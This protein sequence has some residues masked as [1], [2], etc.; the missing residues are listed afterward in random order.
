MSNTV[1]TSLPVQEI[2]HEAPANATNSASSGDKPAVVAATP[3]EESS[4]WDEV[5][6]QPL[7]TLYHDQMI[8]SPSHDEGDGE[9]EEGK[10]PVVGEIMD[11]DERSVEAVE[12]AAGAERIENKTEKGNVSSDKN[13]DECLRED[14]VFD[15]ELVGGAL[16]EDKSNRAE[17][18]VTSDEDETSSGESSLKRFSK[19]SKSSEE[20]K[21]DCPALKKAKTLPVKKDLPMIKAP[22]LELKPLPPLPKQPPRKRPNCLFVNHFG[23]RL[24]QKG[25]A[26]KVNVSTKVPMPAPHRISSEESVS[27]K[28]RST[29]SSKTSKTATSNSSDTKKTPTKSIA[30]SSPTTAGSPAQIPS[31]VRIVTPSIKK[32]ITSSARIEDIHMEEDDL[33]PLRH[34]EGGMLDSMHVP[35]INQSLADAGNHPA[36]PMVACQTMM[37]SMM[38]SPRMI[39]MQFGNP[40]VQGRALFMN[41]MQHPQ[42]M[43]MQHQ[44][45]WPGFVAPGMAF[46]QQMNC[47]PGASTGPVAGVTGGSASLQDQQ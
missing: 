37:P 31:E 32:P 27:L 9:E 5:K 17:M 40:F 14:T 25:V 24:D 20:Q 6:M 43:M 22:E 34:D 36:A 42:A 12:P 7:S 35:Y 28:T 3:I 23:T 21:N 39:P 15:L 26:V 38:G 19:P 1:K 29:S 13:E 47:F 44:G 4:D 16:E 8:M 46:P 2:S 11:F 30:K 45:S 10:A 33:E 18:M 41:P